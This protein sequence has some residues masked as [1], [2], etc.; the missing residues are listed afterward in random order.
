MRVRQHLAGVVQGVGRQQ[1]ELGRLASFISA[2]IFIPF[3]IS[4]PIP[5][6]VVVV[7]VVAVDVKIDIVAGFV[8]GGRPRPRQSANMPRRMARRVKQIQIPVAEKVDGGEAGYVQSWGV[9]DGCGKV[10]IFFLSVS[11]SSWFRV[12][13]D[14][15]SDASVCDT[16]GPLVA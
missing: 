1:D 6:V 4:I 14:P 12:C 3:S 7:V 13:S 15:D 16:L 8:G 5:I 10:F 9:A 2:L 11:F